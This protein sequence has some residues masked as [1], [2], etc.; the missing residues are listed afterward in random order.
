MKLSSLILI[1]QTYN[2]VGKGWAILTV[3]HRGVVSLEVDGHVVVVSV[4]DPAS[5]K[6]QHII[7]LTACKF[8]QVLVEAKLR[9]AALSADEKG[10]RPSKSA[11]K[12][13][14]PLTAPEA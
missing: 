5:G 13:S 6:K 7:P 9:P 4:D 1:D 10:S 3:G 8:G 12:V 14:P 11:A 2:C